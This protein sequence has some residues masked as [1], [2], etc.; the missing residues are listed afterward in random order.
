MSGGSEK[1][2][3]THAPLENPELVTK[4]QVERYCLEK[5]YRLVKDEDLFC[6]C[7]KPI[8]AIGVGHKGN[9]VLMCRTC[10]PKCRECGECVDCDYGVTGPE[11][12]CYHCAIG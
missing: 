7:A 11:K 10:D 4:Q 12:L 6:P 2:R 5:G 8:P 9:S 1:K 3:K